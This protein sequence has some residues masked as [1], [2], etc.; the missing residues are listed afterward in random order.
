MQAE[1]KWLSP[2]L[3]GNR[4]RWARRSAPRALGLSPS[5]TCDHTRK[6]GDRSKT[7]HARLVHHTQT[8]QPTKVQTRAAA[9]I[10]D[11]RLV[12]NKAGPRPVALHGRG[13]FEQ[14]P[15]LFSR[16]FRQAGKKTT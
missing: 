12:V 7:T 10:A 15:P 14:G 4:T 3:A 6:K 1:K 2:D 9:D 13:R 5:R 16:V 11:G 8:W